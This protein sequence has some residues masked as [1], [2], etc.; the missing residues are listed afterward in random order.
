MEGVAFG[1]QR[2]FDCRVIL[3]HPI[4]DQGNFAALIGVWVGVGVVRFAVRCPSGVANA[5]GPFQGFWAQHRLKVA[6]LPCFF[7][8][9]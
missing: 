6:Y 7:L 8:D 9:R 2:F 5:N 1:F 3:N 4:V